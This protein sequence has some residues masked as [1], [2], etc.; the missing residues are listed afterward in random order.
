MLRGVQ[1]HCQVFAVTLNKL[2]IISVSSLSCKMGILRRPGSEGTLEEWRVACWDGVVGWL[3]GWPWQIMEAQKAWAVSWG[4]LGGVFLV[5]WW[6]QLTLFW[7]HL[8]ARCL[9]RHLAEI[10]SFNPYKSLRDCPDTIV[11]YLQW[12]QNFG[13]STW[14]K[15]KGK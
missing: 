4:S 5:K 14:P 6:Q 12:T 11:P 9:A 15:S 7:H 13:V 10:I 2:L 8:G 3:E 1:M